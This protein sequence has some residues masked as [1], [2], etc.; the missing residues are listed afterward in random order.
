MP[1]VNL[2]VAGT[3]TKE[4]KKTIVKEFSDTLAKVAGRAPETTY[5]VIDEVSRENWAKG[6][7]LLE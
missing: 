4:Q 6:G 5:I 2:K 1:Y 3:L 7:D